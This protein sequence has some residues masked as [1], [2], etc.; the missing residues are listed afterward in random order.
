VAPRDGGLGYFRGMHE[1]I[2]ELVAHKYVLPFYDDMPLGITS[3]A[4]ELLRVALDAPLDE[5][6]YLLESHEWRS[7]QIGAWLAIGRDETE[8]VEAVYASL[9]TAAGTLTAP[10]LAAAALALGGAQ[11]V[12]TLRQCLARI[13]VNE[14][15]LKSLIE[16]AIEVGTALPAAL[17]STDGRRSGFDGYW[18]VASA[19]L[20]AKEA[21]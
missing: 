3:R 17:T 7:R 13:P 16:R 20:T 21:E 2:D 10:E 6:L 9:L 11:S 19:I 1:S 18:A 8:V 12:P 4:S 5:I 15:D 14:T